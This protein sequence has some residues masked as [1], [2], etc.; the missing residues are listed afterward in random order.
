MFAI[1]ILKG[2]RVCVGEWGYSSFRQQYQIQ[3]NKFQSR[4]NPI[5]KS[6]K[7]WLAT[8]EYLSPELLQ[9]VIAQSN[10]QEPDIWEQ[11]S[12][13]D[14]WSLGITLYQILT[15][16]PIWI[17]DVCAYKLKTK[18]Q[19]VRSGLLGTEDRKLQKIAEKQKKMEKHISQCLQNE[20]EQGT[21]GQI[22]EL[23][24][25]MLVYNPEQRISLD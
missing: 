12:S 8:P 4:V 25:R 22:Q 24:S 23:V 10:E 16:I 3:D 1:F 15:M 9:A 21:N 11:K 7:E 2:N 19:V 18:K 6:N 5:L 13:S 14:I 17:N 20:L